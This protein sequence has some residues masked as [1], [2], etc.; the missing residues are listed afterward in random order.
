MDT[1]DQSRLDFCPLPVCSSLLWYPQCSP[2]GP[3]PIFRQ[4]FLFYMDVLQPLDPMP[5]MAT[6]AT[7]WP[8]PTLFKLHGYPCWYRSNS[9]CAPCSTAYSSFPAS[10]SL[11]PPRRC[12][13]FP[14]LFML[15]LQ[16]SCRPRAPARRPPVLST[17]FSLFGLRGS[18]E[19]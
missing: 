16:G 4:S 14:L 18:V 9:P 5:P 7:F 6:C 2:P 19:I 17:V 12:S 15:L 10:T 11:Q 1:L 8:L 3:V 13:P